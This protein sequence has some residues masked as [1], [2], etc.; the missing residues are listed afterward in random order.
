MHFIGMMALQI[1]GCEMRFD[2]FLCVLSAIVAVIF[3]FIG[4]YLAMGSGF[5]V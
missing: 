3:V 5:K 4:F 2:L 1:E